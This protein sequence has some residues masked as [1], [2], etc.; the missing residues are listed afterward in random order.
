[1]VDEKAMRWIGLAATYAVEGGAV[2]KVLGG[3]AV[4]AVVA[5]FGI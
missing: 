5:V 4:A 2:E 3:A 1:L